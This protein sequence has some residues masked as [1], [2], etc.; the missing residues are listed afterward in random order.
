MLLLREAS[1][2]QTLLLRYF[3]TKGIETYLWKT[4]MKEPPEEEEIIDNTVY[5]ILSLSDIEEETARFLAKRD[6]QRKRQIE[7]LKN[8]PEETLVEY[9]KSSGKGVIKTLI[10]AI[11][12]FLLGGIAMLSGKIQSFIRG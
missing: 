4:N 8:P 7:D 2:T 12:V 9:A 1:S 3:N 11:V 5:Q 10:A 6:E